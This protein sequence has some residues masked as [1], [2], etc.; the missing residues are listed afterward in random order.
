MF[1]YSE[2]KTMNSDYDKSEKQSPYQNIANDIASHLSKYPAAE[3]SEILAGVKRSLTM[4][5]SEKIDSL[6]KELEHLSREREIIN[7]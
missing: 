6:K 3:V 7:N 5:L 1:E 2:P 4:N